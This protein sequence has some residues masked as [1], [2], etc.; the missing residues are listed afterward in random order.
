[1]SVQLGPEYAAAETP[2][3]SN[4]E[5]Y[6]IAVRD[7]SV[8][9]A[10]IKQLSTA[11]RNLDKPTFELSSVIK[12]LVDELEMTGSRIGDDSELNSDS[13]TLRTIK[14]SSVNPR[15]IDWLW[16]GYIALGKLT[17]IAGD[18]GLGKSILSAALASH[19]SNGKPWPVDNSKCPQ[20]SIVMASA[21]DDAE[22][23][24]R[25][26]LDAAG[27]DVEKVHLI[28]SIHEPDYD[29]KMIRRAFSIKTD[30]EALC[31]VVIAKP[32]CKLVTIDPISAYLGG[33]DS[34]NNSDIR[35]L[36]MPLADL[37]Q[38]QRVAIVA[39]THLNKG[40]SNAMYRAMGSLAF[41]AAARAAFAVTKDKDDT[42]R[43]LF[44]PIKNNLGND[45][46]G[47][48]YSIQTGE[49]DAPFIVWENENISISAD[50]A[51]STMSE[52]DSSS[53]GD[54]KHFLLTELE[55][56]TVKVKDLQKSAKESG[57][58]WR[59]IERAKSRLGIKA[60]K[61]RFDGY[62]EW[63]KTMS[64]KTPYTQKHGGVGGVGLNNEEKHRTPPENP[65]TDKF[66]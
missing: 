23:T 21:E 14:V 48:A 40:T 46:D 62:W 52:E 42:K 10:L 53:L 18:P 5:A 56:G 2:S 39:I 64:A 65:K 16:P 55:K 22:D 38:K 11:I 41:V 54:A 49:N 43:R 66:S 24:I 47:F 3:A 9:R 1:M 58:A 6:A 36:L 13:S 26:R 51:L 61:R 34:H 35:S 60:N 17:L 15:S 44:L 59:T 45:Q 8:K 29:G 50:E 57:I 33:T 20:G 27:A 4:I 7:A 32:D 63:S 12:K 31:N 30:I 37:A 19:V 28:D 25:P